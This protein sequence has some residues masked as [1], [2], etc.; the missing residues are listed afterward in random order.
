MAE[1]P[2]KPR[3][4]QPARGS[5][6]SASTPKGSKSSGSKPKGSKSSGKKGARKQVSPF[7]KWSVRI[8]QG[9]AIVVLLALIAGIAGMAI[10][11]ARTDIPDPNEEFQANTS[12][13]NYRDGS[14]MGS[15]AS[16]NRQTIPFEEMPDSLKNAAVAAENRTFWTDG[17]SRR[18]A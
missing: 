11:Y 2:K 15:F 18:W 12:F 4:G 17:A 13:V 3:S 7:R 14:K 8:L 5:K 1:A 6:K 9:T 10:G 16:Q